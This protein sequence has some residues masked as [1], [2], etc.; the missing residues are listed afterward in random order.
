MPILIQDV[1]FP[2]S[3]PQPATA[4]ADHFPIHVQERGLPDSQPYNTAIAEYGFM[5]ENQSNLATLF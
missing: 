5:M 1:R 2:V 4:S 3:I